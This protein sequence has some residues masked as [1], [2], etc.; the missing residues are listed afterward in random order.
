MAAL[1]QMEKGESERMRQRYFEKIPGKKPWKRI[2]REPTAV[3]EDSLEI[4]EL[5]P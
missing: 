3:V 4:E 2:E 5:F 1:K